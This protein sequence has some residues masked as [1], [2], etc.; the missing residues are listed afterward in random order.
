M[1][2]WKNVENKKYRSTFVYD[3]VCEREGGVNP[4]LCFLS[5]SFN[6]CKK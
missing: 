5:V 3:A 1:K 4:C 2:R 6:N